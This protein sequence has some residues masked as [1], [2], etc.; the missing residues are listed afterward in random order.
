LTGILSLWPPFTPL[1]AQPA[2][3]TDYS[4]ILLQGYD[5]GLVLVQ[6]Y[7]DPAPGSPSALID[8]RRPGHDSYC[9]A[10]PSPQLILGAILWALRQHFIDRGSIRAAQL[11]DHANPDPATVPPPVD[12]LDRIVIVPIDLF[13]PELA[14]RV[15][16]IVVRDDDNTFAPTGINDQHDGGLSLDGSRYYSTMLVGSISLVACAETITLARELGRETYVCLL[17]AVPILRGALNL[18]R[19]RL[20]GASAPREVKQINGYGVYITI[21]FAYTEERLLRPHAPRIK[22]LSIET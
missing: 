20:G 17:G 7:G 14:D 3:P 22:R 19:L 18:K 21:Q 15:P 13:S 8:D 10:G 2:Q 11:R 9:S 12:Q 1:I 5:G 6:G 4:H 16:T